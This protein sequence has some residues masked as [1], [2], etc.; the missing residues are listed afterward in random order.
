MASFKARPPPTFNPAVNDY[1]SF[2]NWRKVFTTYCNVSEF[3]TPDISLAIQRDRLFNIAGGDFQLFAEQH[4]TLHVDNTISNILD[5]IANALKPKRMDLQNRAN[6]TPIEI[7]GSISNALLETPNGFIVDTVW[8]AKNLTSGA[9]LGQSSLSA[10]QALTLQYGGHLPPL[11]VH[12]VTQKVP[13]SFTTHPPVQCFSNWDNT[14]T[15]I[16]APSRR[17][18][19]DD[20]LFIRAEIQRLGQSQIQGSKK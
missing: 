18:Q 14:Q 5:A 12:Q 10:F 13:N 20:K 15:P 4:I 16:R 11:N 6:G 1:T 7:I 2:S 19:P 17:Q 8:V 9:I 3:F